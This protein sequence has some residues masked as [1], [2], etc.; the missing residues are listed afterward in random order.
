M[1]STLNLL[2]ATYNDASNSNEMDDAIEVSGAY[3]F[4]GWSKIISDNNDIVRLANIFLSSFKS[5]RELIREKAHD[6]LIM[7]GPLPSK[8]VVLVPK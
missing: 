1:P 2:I 6:D 7:S 8:R 5:T 4:F 3:P